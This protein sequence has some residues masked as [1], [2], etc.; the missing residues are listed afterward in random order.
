LRTEPSLP[1]DSSRF[2]RDETG[3][4]NREAAVMRRVPGVGAVGELALG[5][6]G[7]LQMKKKGQRT[8]YG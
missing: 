5:S 8:F 6:G 7:V 2:R 4:T 3:A 1:T